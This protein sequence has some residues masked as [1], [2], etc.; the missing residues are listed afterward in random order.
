MEISVIMSVYNTRE[1]YLRKAIE[2]I[3]EQSFIDFEFIIINDGSKK[4]VR[5]TIKSYQDER[6]IFINNECNIGLTKSLNKGLDIARGKY[7]ARMDADDVSHKRRL[8]KQYK[9]MEK[10]QN[11]DI[12]GAWINDGKCTIKTD[13]R[14]SSECRKVRMLFKNAGIIHPTAFIRKKFLVENEIRYDE[15]IKKAQ[16][17]KLW[18]DCL[19]KG[20]Q[21]SVYP[22]VLLY[23]RRHGGQITEEKSGEQ[24]YFRKIIQEALVREI[25]ADISESELNM[26]FNNERRLQYKE[27][28]VKLCRTLEEEN[29]IKRLYDDTIL[30]YELKDTYI[31]F[32]KQDYFDIGYWCYRLKRYIAK[33]GV[34]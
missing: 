1:D 7:I 6:I 20:A 24:D 11:V 9:Y 5:D 33:C 15:T 22:G 14:I 3:L 34:F 8:E 4:E 31:K 10:H 13:G 26:F 29:S 25:Y 19:K 21:I 2:S 17:Y 30:R 16:D 32:R 27:E 28:Y 23:Y 18:V 12:L